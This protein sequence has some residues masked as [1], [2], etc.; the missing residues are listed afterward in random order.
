MRPLNLLIF[1]VLTC[2]CMLFAFCCL[3]TKKDSNHPR[4]NESYSV[5]LSNLNV[6]MNEKDAR[7]GVFYYLTHEQKILHSLFSQATGLFTLFSIDDQG[8]S[9]LLNHLPIEHF[10]VGDLLMSY[11]RK[12][13]SL[14]LLSLDGKSNVINT[15]SLSEGLENYSIAGTRA[16]P[17]SIMFLK[18]QS[19][20]SIEIIKWQLEKERPMRTDLTLSAESIFHGNY[21]ELR[22]TTSFTYIIR[23]KYILIQSEEGMLFY[24]S[25]ASY[26]KSYSYSQIPGIKEAM[27]DNWYMCYTNKFIIGID[28]YI[29]KPDNWIILHKISNDLEITRCDVNGKDQQKAANQIGATKGAKID[30]WSTSSDESVLAI[31]EGNFMVLSLKST[32][33]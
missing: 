6:S 28:I 29:E 4:N 32:D 5:L 17:I 21:D 13:N 2:S 7:A 16:Q 14:S 3:D 12:N 24:D 15:Y 18:E 33:E 19:K 22:E 30:I 23:D 11:D 31:Y 26:S 25:D 10:F 20:E 1:Y 9:T 27:K 8:T